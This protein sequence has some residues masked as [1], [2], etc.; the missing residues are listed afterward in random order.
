MFG[1]VF[2]VVAICPSAALCQAGDAGDEQPVDK[3]QLESIFEKGDGRVTL[4]GRRI[5]GP[6]LVSVMT[7]DKYSDCNVTI[8][9]C[10]IDNGLHFR[11]A[12]QEANPAEA[13][14]DFGSDPHDVQ[15]WIA[16]PYMYGIHRKPL[17]KVR[18]MKSRLLVVDSEIHDAPLSPRMDLGAYSL[19]GSEVVF[20]E[21]L[22]FNR[23]TF[24]GGVRFKNAAFARRL[25]VRDCV[26]HGM[27]SLVHTYCLDTLT[28]QRCAL[29]QPLLVGD[30][31]FARSFQLDDSEFRSTVDVG[32]S[33]FR[34]SLSVTGTSFHE[35]LGFRASEIDEL[36]IGSRFGRTVVSA[37][38]DLR[39][40]KVRRASIGRTTFR[41]PVDFSDVEF[42]E[43]EA[44]DD[45][46]GLELQYVTFE[47]NVDFIRAILSGQ[48][49]FVHTS[50]KQQANFDEAVF[51]GQMRPRFQFSYVDFESVR[52]HWDQ[53]PPVEEWGAPAPGESSADETGSAPPYNWFLGESPPATQPTSVALKSLEMVFRRQ[54]Q[55]Y[56]AN[57]AYREYK[58]AGLREE[59][60]AGIS[61]RRIWLELEG[62]AWGFVCGYGTSLWRILVLILGVNLVFTAIFAVAGELQTSESAEKDEKPGVKLRLFD[63]PGRYV[64]AEDEVEGS[65]ATSRWLRAW[66]LSATILLK[67]GRRDTRITGRCCKMNL[68]HFVQV[69]WYLGFYLLFALV[70]TLSSTQPFLYKMLSG[71][72]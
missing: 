15:Q 45:P 65:A 67:V 56:D 11:D 13:L 60:L 71:V 32:D 12:G 66:W 47:N 19:Y 52:L 53:L 49:R 10:V 21:R 62:L 33:R 72:F 55:L 24:H 3:H 46:G 18:V 28:L 8:A 36:R 25:D 63:L 44:S 23:V 30:S 61:L 6:E 4:S 31:L 43:H 39:G 35:Y 7:S 34:G 22:D 68:L 9:D 40:A 58:A 37:L 41:E 50:F 16:K 69:E 17:S 5:G 51:R 29:S 38:F 42:G 54:G 57:Q 14:A 59:R 48:T 1:L 70:V 64:V 26:V 2:V 27:T 20:S